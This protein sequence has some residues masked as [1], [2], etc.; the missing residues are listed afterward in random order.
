MNGDRE[1]IGVLIKDLLHPVAVMAVDIDV[2]DSLNRFFRTQIAS[3]G[4]LKT[5][6]PEAW[7]GKA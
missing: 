6:K 4:S 5:Q 2:K 1:H 3:A 7:V